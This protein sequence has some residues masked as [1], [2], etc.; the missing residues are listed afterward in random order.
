MFVGTRGRHLCSP[1]WARGLARSRC[2]TR[3]WIIYG[4]SRRMLGESPARA[5]LALFLY[6]GGHGEPPQPY[7]QSLLCWGARPWAKGTGIFQKNYNG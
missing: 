3:I 4:T 2:A 1:L 6:L 5:W 7:L